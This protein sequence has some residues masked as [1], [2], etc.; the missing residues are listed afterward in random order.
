MNKYKILLSSTVILTSLV[1]F[2]TI[3]S[4]DEVK[5]EVQEVTTE[6][7]VINKENNIVNK[8][9][10]VLIHE[11]GVAEEPVIP[12]VTTSQPSTVESPTE[13][14]VI[15]A[16][17]TVPDTTT[18]TDTKPSEEPVIP[19][20]Q[21]VL[22][23]TTQT[24]TKP[25]EEPVIPTEPE[26]PTETTQS[27]EKPTEQPTETTNSTTS[28]VEKPTETPAPTQQNGGST[29]LTEIL[30]SSN[31]ANEFYETD[32]GSLDF[33]NLTFAFDIKTEGTKKESNKEDKDKEGELKVLPNTGTSSSASV[34]IIGGIIALAGSYLGFNKK[35]EN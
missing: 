8:E 23:T 16:V 29:K 5:P 9:T 25:S 18:Q 13:S 6:H 12:A 28:E 15:P 2:S 10:K 3:A 27:T 14:P 26:K 30:N 24:D 17:P 4:A 32:S 11:P 1:S 20:V 7:I 21:T 19:A 35:K 34:S 33:S 22:D 31:N